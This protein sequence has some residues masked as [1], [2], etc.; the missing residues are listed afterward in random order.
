[1]FSVQRPNLQH[2]EEHDKEEELLRDGTW[3]HLL[4]DVE[5]NKKLFAANSAVL[6]KISKAVNSIV[7]DSRTP[8]EV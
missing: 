2:G 7:V 6:K 8:V 5:L 1:M 4:S 3:H